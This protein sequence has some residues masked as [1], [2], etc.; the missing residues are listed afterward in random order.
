MEALWV[1]I[2]V[3]V[4]FFK[5][6]GK[7]NDMKEK[8]PGEWKNKIPREWRETGLPPILREMGFPWDEPE[9]EAPKAQSEKLAEW[10]LDEMEAVQEVPA[11]AP[12]PVTAAPKAA[13]LGPDEQGYSLQVMDKQ[14][15]LNGII[16][17][18][19]LQPPLSKRGRRR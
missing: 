5:V 3:A 7:L 14:L 1:I 18:E 10:Q 13:A 4:V 2:A 12:K 19:L 16:F 15:V 17:S 11:A 6:F 8:T 9:E